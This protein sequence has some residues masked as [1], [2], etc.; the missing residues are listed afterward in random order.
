MFLDEGFEEKMLRIERENEALSERLIADQKRLGSNLRQAIK[1]LNT[2]ITSRQFMVLRDIALTRM[3]VDGNWDPLTEDSVS[4]P[5][6]L[7]AS[8]VQGD[9]KQVVDGES[10]KLREGLVMVASQLVEWIEV[11]DLKRHHP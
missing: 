5:Y 7:R 11:I 10:S 6:S 2:K 8:A 4:Y 1:E 9:L 3:L